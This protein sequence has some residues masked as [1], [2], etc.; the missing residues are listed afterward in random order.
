[1][2]PCDLMELRL[3]AL[4]DGE[5][6]PEEAALLE[7]HLAECADC[8]ARHRELQA[9]LGL[10]DR[11]EIPPAPSVPTVVAHE[12]SLMGTLLAELRSL[13]DEV[14]GLRAEVAGLRQELRMESRRNATPATTTVTR[15]NLRTEPATLLPYAPPVEADLLSH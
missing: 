7:S 11:W 6:P 8:Q 3:V 4:L 14:N 15:A 1:M 10:A 12:E 2:T 5:L 13:R 9:V